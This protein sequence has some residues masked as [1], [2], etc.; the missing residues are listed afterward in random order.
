[1]TWCMPKKLVAMRD[2]FQNELTAFV[3][4][5]REVWDE[6]SE[7]WQNSADG[8]AVADWLDR[9]ESVLDALEDADAQPEGD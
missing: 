5:G 2:Q 7:R 6:R 4:D 3:E 1:M 9:L 8:R